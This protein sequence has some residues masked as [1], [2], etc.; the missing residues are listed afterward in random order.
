[1][2]GGI[3]MLNNIARLGLIGI[4]ARLEPGLSTVKMRPYSASRLCYL[5]SW[6]MEGVLRKSLDRL[7]GE[8]APLVN[9]SGVQLSCPNNLALAT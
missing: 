6:P 1:M 5:P 4:S 9:H 3:S 2:V 8:R 7:I